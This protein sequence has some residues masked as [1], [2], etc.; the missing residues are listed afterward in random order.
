MSNASL[1]KSK[2]NDTEIRDHI[3]PILVEGYYIQ[4]ILNDLNIFARLTDSQFQLKKETIRLVPFFKEIIIQII[5][6]R[7]LGKLSI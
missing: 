5:N 6:Q 1:A 2:S 3:E 7:Y 4:N